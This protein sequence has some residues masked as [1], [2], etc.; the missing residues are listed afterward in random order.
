VTTAAPA[1]GDGFCSA[2]G[3]LVTLGDILVSLTSELPGPLGRGQRLVM[4]VAGAEA[5]TAVGVRRLG[6]PVSW[7]GAVSGDG[8]GDLIVRELRA[9]GVAVRARRHPAPTALLVRTQ[10]TS[11]HSTIDYYRA[12]TAGTTL[13]P[14]DLDLD[15]IRSAALLHV[16]GVTPALGRGPAAA[17]RTAVETAREAGVEVSCALNHRSRLWS[18]EEARPELLWLVERSSVV[19]ASVA[20]AEI[21]L[22]SRNG[23]EDAA[24]T[25]V[26]LAALGPAEAVV[27]DGGGPV[28]VHA[29]GTASLHHPL[30]RQVTDTVG[31]GDALAAGYLAARMR[32]LPAAERIRVA[33]AT[34]RFAVTTVGD[35]DGLPTWDEI[36]AD[37]D[38]SD[39]TIR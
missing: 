5:N 35:W 20:E 19:F 12:G 32:G 7:A 25:A 11:E 29:D 8:F 4:R 1:F 33:L 28:G 15:T 13:T 3:G 17:V 38:P 34:A 31:A 21:V 26:K 36:A 23:S 39:D 24:E 22:G 10:R 2:A 9:E 16:T 27:S 6:L 18:R 30:A 37:R 14:A